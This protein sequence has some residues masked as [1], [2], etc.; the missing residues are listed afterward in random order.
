MLGAAAALRGRSWGAAARVCCNTRTETESESGLE[1]ER[2]GLA[3][4]QAFPAAAAASCGET[5][6][7]TRIAI[8]RPDSHLM[9]MSNHFA[10]S[11]TIFDQQ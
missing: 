6:P 11:V 9:S 8:A 4:G 10:K 1:I 3:T 5:A 2:L 7:P